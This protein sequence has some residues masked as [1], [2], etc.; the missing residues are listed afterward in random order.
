VEQR[1]VD[2]ERVELVVGGQ[3]HDDGVPRQLGRRLSQL[4]QQRVA[5]RTGGEPQEHASGGGRQGCGRQQVVGRSAGSRARWGSALPRRAVAAAAPRPRARRRRCAPSRSRR[6]AAPR[7]RSTTAPDAPCARSPR[8]PGAGCDRGARACADATTRGALSASASRRVSAGRGGSMRSTASSGSGMTDSRLPRRSSG[9]V[10]LRRGPGR[11]AVPRAAR[12]AAAG[13]SR[14]RR[15]PPA[16]R[17]GRAGGV[18][19]GRGRI[20]LA[21]VRVRGARHFGQADAAPGAG[22]VRVVDDDHVAD[23]HLVAQVVA[24]LVVADAVPRGAALG[25]RHRSSN[26][27]VSGSVFT[28]QPRPSPAGRGG[29]RTAHSHSIVPG[30]FDVTSYTTR[31]TSGTALTIRFDTV[32]RNSC[33]R[34]RPVGRH[35]VDRRHGA[36]RDRVA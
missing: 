36:Q 16:R 20:E 7:L 34:A 8:P 13:P 23:A 31:L 21:R 19:V 5:V 6:R 17:R 22:R 28:S 4:L 15:R 18:V 9:Q 14:A 27:K 12:A 25:A 32:A 11:R 24:G 30:G 1:Q 33:G 10:E 2:L 35:A 29:P 3:R 26:P